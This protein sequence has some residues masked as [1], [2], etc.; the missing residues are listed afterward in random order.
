MKQCFKVYWTG[1]EQDGDID[2]V[3]KKINAPIAKMLEDGWVVVNSQ[4]NLSNQTQNIV[5][6]WSDPYVYNCPILTVSVLFEKPDAPPRQ[7]RSSRQPK[8]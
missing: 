1:V 4:S 6:D 7:C 5:E 8:N 2:H 3:E